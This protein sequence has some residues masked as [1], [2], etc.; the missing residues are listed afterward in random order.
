MPRFV[1]RGR[2]TPEGIRKVRVAKSTV[3]Q[4]FAASAH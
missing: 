1:G 4:D 2:N 3:M